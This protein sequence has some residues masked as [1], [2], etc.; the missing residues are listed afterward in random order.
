MVIGR[1]QNMATLGYQITRGVGQL[2]TT[3]GGIM[4]TIMDGNG[5]RVTTG[6]LPGLAGATVAV[7]MA[8]HRW[9]QV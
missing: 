3:A 4:M 6:H 1:K 2:S 5:Y 8:G 7:I 9:M